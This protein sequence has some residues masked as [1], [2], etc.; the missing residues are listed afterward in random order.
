MKEQ[1]REAGLTENESKVYVTLLELGPS[2]AGLIS[3]RCGLHRRVVYDTLEMLI[4]K[5]LV[6]YIMQNNIKLFQCVHPHRLIER[7]QEKEKAL[8]EFMPSLIERFAKT[9]EKEETNFYTGKNGLKTVFEDQ[10]AIGKEILVLGASPLAYEMLELYFHWFDKRRVARKVK[11]RVIFHEGIE[12]KIPLSEVRYLPQKYASPLAVNIYGDK[13]ALI[14]WSKEKPLAIVINNR[15]I[16][17]GYRNYFELLW[18]TA[19]KRKV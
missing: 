2:H 13:V 15:D 17:E 14:L 4:Q 5:G 18:K 16:S 8:E 1:L 11:T 7:L 10:I 9:K 6:G 12:R 19:R 3:R